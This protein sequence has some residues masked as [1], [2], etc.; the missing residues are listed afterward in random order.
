MSNGLIVRAFKD[1]VF[2]AVDAV[3]LQT[4]AIIFKDARSRGIIR[5]IGAMI[6][7]GPDGLIRRDREP[8][9]FWTYVS[10]GGLVAFGGAITA[11][12]II[13]RF[14]VALWRTWF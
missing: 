9:A 14:G 13:L 3:S 5:P 10:L 7:F 1:L 6:K 8:T 11:L 12:V 4:L 2:L